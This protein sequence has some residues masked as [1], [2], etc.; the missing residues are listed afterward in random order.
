MHGG[1]RAEGSRW[2]LSRPRSAPLDVPESMLEQLDAVEQ[3]DNERGPFVVDAEVTLPAHELP[4]PQR[5]FASKTPLATGMGADDAE[6]DEAIDEGHV[7]TATQGDVV[8]AVQ[9]V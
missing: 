1:P 6:L 2:A 5:D 4:D 3:L 9:G 7:D 8:H